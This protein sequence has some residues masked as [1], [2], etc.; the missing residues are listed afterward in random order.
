MFFDVVRQFLIYQTLVF[1]LE[2]NMDHMVVGFQSSCGKKRMRLLLVKIDKVGYQLVNG[3]VFGITVGVDNRVQIILN[4][5]VFDLSFMV[6]M[7]TPKNP[8]K[9]YTDKFVLQPTM[10]QETKQPTVFWE[11]G[12]K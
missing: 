9:R 12:N 2:K 1:Q 4:D 6:T 5:I 10:I 8:T 11:H 3:Q 7:I